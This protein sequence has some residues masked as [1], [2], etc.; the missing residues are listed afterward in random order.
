MMIPA[1][2]LNVSVSS[3]VVAFV[4]TSLVV[5]DTPILGSAVVPLAMGAPTL[6]VTLGVGTAVVGLSSVLGMVLLGTIRTASKSLVAE[7]AGVRSSTG[8]AGVGA[9]AL[10]PVVLPAGAV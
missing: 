9:V 5:L 7:A 8:M 2:S 6:V 3:D 1:V 10:A 4:T